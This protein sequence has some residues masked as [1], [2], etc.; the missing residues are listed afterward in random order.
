MRFKVAEQE[1]MK[2][3]FDIH[4]QVKARKAEVDKRLKEFGAKVLKKDSATDYAFR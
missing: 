3:G 2:D 4:H 1:D